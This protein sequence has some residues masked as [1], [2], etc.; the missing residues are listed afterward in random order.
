MLAIYDLIDQLR[1]ELRDCA[2]SH[3]ERVAAHVT[4]AQ[5]IAEQGKLNAAFEA[6]LAAYTPPD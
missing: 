6:D 1:R 5:L 2:L 3:A 4:L